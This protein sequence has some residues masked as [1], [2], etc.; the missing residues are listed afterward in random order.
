MTELNDKEL[1]VET[2]EP[3]T[4]YV[5][6]TIKNPEGKG[7][8][9]AYRRQQSIGLKS[10]K[11][12]YKLE[13]PILKIPETETNYVVTTLSREVRRKRIIDVAAVL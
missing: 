13:P 5:A 2:P 10:G 6:L 1:N 11:V 12:F 7:R 9:L 8:V 4:V 3:Q